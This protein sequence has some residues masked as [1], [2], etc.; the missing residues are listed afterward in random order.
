[1]PGPRPRARLSIGPA[2]KPAAA[3][4]P[5]SRFVASQSFLAIA[6][7]PGRNRSSSRRRRRV[8]VLIGLPAAAIVVEE[9]DARESW[10]RVLVLL[11]CAGP[12]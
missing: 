1:L 4:S 12:E 5:R 10:I 3:R 9:S 8:I 6:R 11:Q 2:A 7:R